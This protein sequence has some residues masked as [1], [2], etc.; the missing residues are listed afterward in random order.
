MWHQPIGR[1]V[2]VHLKHVYPSR[3]L[4]VHPIGS[5]EHLSPRKTSINRGSAHLFR[6]LTDVSITSM[7][8]LF[9]G[10]QVQSNYVKPTKL[11]NHIECCAGDSEIFGINSHYR[12][13]SDRCSIVDCAGTWCFN[14]ASVI[15]EGFLDSNHSV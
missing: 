2:P 15:L 14:G 13:E 11:N 4:G 3:A 7:C 10:D 5:L 12:S 6:H 1:K 9:A 8:F